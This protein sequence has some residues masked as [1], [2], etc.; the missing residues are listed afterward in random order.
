MSRKKIIW[1]IILL[2]VV[3]GIV[4][5][6]KEYTRTNR[7]IK[8]VRPDFTVTSLDL[9]REF[10]Q[11]DSTASKKYNGKILEVKGNVKAVEV[12]GMAYYTIVLGDSSGLSSVRCSLDTTHQNDATGIQAGKSV[13]IR[14]VCTGF[15]E[16]D[17]GLGS[18]VILNRCVIVSNKP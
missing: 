10:E 12:D 1:S 3:V 17:L 18:D 5:G 11:S 9:M 4:Y 14:G 16:L 2:A 6:Y 8:N 7:D 13:S 15:N